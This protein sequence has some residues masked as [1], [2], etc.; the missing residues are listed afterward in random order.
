[1]NKFARI[2]PIHSP[3]FRI[4]TAEAVFSP[5]CPFLLRITRLSGLSSGG[6][7]SSEDRD[8][9]GDRM[10]VWEANSGSRNWYFQGRKGGG[11]NGCVVIVDNDKMRNLLHIA[12]SIRNDTIV[13][14]PR[15]KVV[16]C[17]VQSASAFFRLGCRRPR[18]EEDGG[19]VAHRE[20]N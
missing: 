4:D 5:L 14:I 2:A 13:S 8:W 16:I 1:M 12:F 17:R 10:W 20:F 15:L 3:T 18:R 9:N 6:G 7:A 19:F 11:K